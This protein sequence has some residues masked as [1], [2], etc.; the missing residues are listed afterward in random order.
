M[1]VARGG[2][3]TKTKPAKA[4][5]ENGRAVGARQSEAPAR[6]SFGS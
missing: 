6:P 4:S 1:K 2:V 5:A 3:V